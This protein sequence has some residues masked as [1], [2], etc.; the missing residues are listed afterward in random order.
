[1][2]CYHPITGY[3]SKTVNPSGKRSIVF[4]PSEG[5][6]DL[7]VE[8]PCGQC[9][10]CRLDRSRSWAV[11]CMHEN[12]LHDKS[13]FLTLTFDDEHLDPKKSL[14]KADFQNF[15]KRLRRYYEP[16]RIRF[17]HCG[18]YGER[19][20]RPH[21]HAILFGIDFE[22]KELFQV[23]NDTKLYT[24]KTLQ[25]LWKKG[26]CTIGE[27][28]FDSAA[29]V[30]RYITKKITGKPAKEHYGERLPEYNTSS[31][32]PG[33]G[34]DWLLKYASDVYPDDFIVIRNNITCKPPKYY[35][36][37]YHNFEPFLID[38]IKAKRFAKAKSNLDN[39]TEARLTIR[40]R[41]TYIKLN[42]LKRDI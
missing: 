16:T 21:H 8:L 36:D 6:I 38:K 41:L 24:S 2:P 40:E 31:N 3:R 35:D 42:E 9:I 22:D 26:F 28:T 10:G 17:M 11:R 37:I 19:Y 12:Q 27:V 25:N 33:I 14:V 13:C 39:Q 30:A 15:M 18:E 29:Y 20:N 23:N 5:F 32:R 7:T 1:M 4:N 34:A